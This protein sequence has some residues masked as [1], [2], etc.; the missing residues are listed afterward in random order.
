MTSLHDKYLRL[1]RY[2]GP[3][4]RQRGGEDPKYG[5]EDREPAR[6]RLFPPSFINL[7]ILP[8]ILPGH[9]MSDF[10]MGECDR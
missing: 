1:S 4:G 5:N 3:R 8:K 9:L 6:R 2:G 7:S 10:V